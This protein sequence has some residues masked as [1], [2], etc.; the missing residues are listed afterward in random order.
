MPKIVFPVRIPLRVFDLSA[1]D[2]DFLRTIEFLHRIQAGIEARQTNDNLENGSRL[3][4]FLRSPVN[5]WTERV[6]HQFGVLLVAHSPDKAVRIESWIGGHR[7]D[8]ARS[9]VHHDYCAADRSMVRNDGT[10]QRLLGRSLNVQVDG[11]NHILARFGGG[12][13]GFRLAITEA[14]DQHRFHPGA[15]AQLLVEG[16]FHADAPAVVGQSKIEKRVFPLG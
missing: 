1:A 9:R 4:V 15:S 10:L 11:E 12:P 7:K 13:N 2:P 5:L 14:V 3:V 6:I 8:V 16:S